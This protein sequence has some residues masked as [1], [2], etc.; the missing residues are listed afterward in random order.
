MTKQVLVDFCERLIYQGLQSGFVLNLGLL[1]SKI[2]KKCN[3]SSQKNT[4][5]N[6]L[7]HFKFPGRISLVENLPVSYV[8][9]SVVW[10]F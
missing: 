1:F 6:I 2:V 7:N 10:Q 9:S 4:N 3:Q 5:N 8:L